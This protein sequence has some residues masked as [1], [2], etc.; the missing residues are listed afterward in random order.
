MIMRYPSAYGRAMVSMTELKRRYSGDMEPEFARRLFA[1]IASKEGAVGIGSGWRPTPSNISAASRAGRSFHQTQT[2]ADGSRHFCAVDLVVPTADKH[3][4]GGVPAASVPLQGSRE[5][6]V[7]G[8]HANVGTP[9]KKGFESWHVQPI[10]IDGFS[11]WANSGRVR[12]TPNRDVPGNPGRVRRPK[13]VGGELGS[14]AP[15]FSAYGLYPV[16]PDKGEVSRDSRPQPDDLVRY[17]QGV[18]TNQCRLSGID[19][20]GFFGDQTAKGVIEVQK[21]NNLEQTGRCDAATW[22][23]IDAYAAI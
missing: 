15:E 16:Q 5:A 21:W 13:S 3:S 23:A 22:D 14:F 4:S 8:V 2:F 19:I 7:W 18:M 11:A 10:E 20:D 12:P 6:E 17:L 1:W 9:G